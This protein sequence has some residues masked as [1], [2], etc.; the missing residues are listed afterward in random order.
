MEVWTQ[1]VWAALLTVDVQF[2]PVRSPPTFC[3]HPGFQLFLLCSLPTAKRTS[4]SASPLV[5]ALQVT[6]SSPGV[7]LHTDPKMVCEVGLCSQG[8]TLRVTASY[9]LVPESNVDTP[10][11]S[12]IIHTVT[13]SHNQCMVATCRAAFFGALPKLYPA[14]SSAGGKGHGQSVISGDCQGWVTEGFL[15]M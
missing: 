1:I 15:Y 8:G 6:F 3:I 12:T 9:H 10:I 14:W 4:I 13:V 7:V 11:R 2:C 5:F